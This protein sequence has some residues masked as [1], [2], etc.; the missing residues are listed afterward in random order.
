[1]G[2]TVFIEETIDND[3]L[4]CFGT[5]SLRIHKRFIVKESGKPCPTPLR[6]TVNG[7][8]PEDSNKVF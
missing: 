7:T 2:W 1:M 3:A 5:P 4:C 8:R 6:F